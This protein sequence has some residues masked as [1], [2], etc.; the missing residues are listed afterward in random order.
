MAV[1]VPGPETEGLQDIHE[2]A[3]HEREGGALGKGLGVP[4]GRP[5]LSGPCCMQKG[6]QQGEVLPWELRRVWEQKELLVPGFREG[7]NWPRLFFPAL[8][9]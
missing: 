2:S 5:P 1:R 8:I 9:T 6:P 4:V 3:A 7:G